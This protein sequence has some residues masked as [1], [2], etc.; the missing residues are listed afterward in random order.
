MQVKLIGKQKLDF[1]TNT[2]DTISGNNLFVAFADENVEGLKTEKLFIKKEI[3]LPE[4]KLNESLEISFN[5]KGKVES[6]AKI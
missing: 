5:M 4:C 3:T 6:V 1:T 2:G